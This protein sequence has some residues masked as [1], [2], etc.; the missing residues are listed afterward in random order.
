MDGKGNLHMWFVWL[1]SMPIISAALLQSFGVVSKAFLLLYRY[2]WMI[3]YY[4]IAAGVTTVLLMWRCFHWMASFSVILSSAMLGV[5]SICTRLFPLLLSKKTLGVVQNMLW[6]FPRLFFFPF[7]SFVS[8]L[9]LSF[10]IFDLIMSAEFSV[11]LTGV[12]HY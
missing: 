10:Y 5:F 3:L 8:F 6:E 11:I 2:P 9:L 1:V 4:L 12:W 7:I